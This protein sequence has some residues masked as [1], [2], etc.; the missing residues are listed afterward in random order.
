MA[1]I[2][3]GAAITDL[4]NAVLSL[5]LAGILSYKLHCAADKCRNR[6]LADSILAFLLAFCLT[7]AG[8]GYAWYSGAM[9][10]KPPE[11][12][13]MLFTFVAMAAQGATLVPG[14]GA[15]LALEACTNLMWVF[16]TL[17]LMLASI[18]L[19]VLF[20]NSYYW[21]RFFASGLAGVGMC[22]LAFCCVIRQIWGS[23][24]QES[25][26]EED[27]ENEEQ[28]GTR[29]VRDD[30]GDAIP[31][32]AFNTVIA[33][34]AIAMAGCAVVLF[35][36]T[37]CYEFSACMYD[38]GHDFD[39][40]NPFTRSLSCPFD[41]R[42]DQFAVLHITYSIAAIGYFAAAWISSSAIDKGTEMRIDNGTEIGTN[43]R[44]FA[45]LKLTD[46]LVTYE[47]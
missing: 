7:S 21:C 39:C 42:F 10:A 16:V 43:P 36:Q 35:F 45:K 33:S 23:S 14:G 22:W 2:H 18:V 29:A 31:V 19:Q 41:G 30:A 11:N 20:R 9:A 27:V 13:S 47:K 12:I 3:H 24:C 5:V 26:S 15:V 6:A 34:T 44:G 46:T 28:H 37:P 32:I 17:I 8:G 4:A 25:D 40:D 38:D 1:E